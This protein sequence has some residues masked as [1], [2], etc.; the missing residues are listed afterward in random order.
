MKKLLIL[1]VVM[2]GWSCIT[3]RKCADRFPPEVNEI[4]KAVTIYRDTTIFVYIKP[5]TVHRVDTVYVDKFGLVQSSVSYLQTEY[6]W[7]RAWIKDSRLFHDV[8]QFDSKI[9]ETIK[10]ATKT[11][12]QYVYRET[13]KEVNILKWWQTILMWAGG[14]MFVCLFGL[15]LVLI[16]RLVL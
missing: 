3:E 14:L 11:E 1:L 7:G 9:A 15:V 6:A 5:D 12:I 8:G 13:I 16:I 10:G 4:T 2:N